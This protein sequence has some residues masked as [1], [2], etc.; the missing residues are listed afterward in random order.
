[1]YLYCRGRIDL[2]III[3]LHTIKLNTS[4][5]KHT[6][7]PLCSVNNLIIF[8]TPFSFFPFTCIYQQVQLLIFIIS[9]IY[10]LTYQKFVLW[11]Y[12]KTKIFVL[13]CLVQSKMSKIVDSRKTFYFTYKT[14]KNC[15]QKTFYKKHYILL[16]SILQLSKQDNYQSVH[17]H[18]TILYYI[19]LLYGV[20][21]IKYIQVFIIFITQYSDQEQEPGRFYLLQ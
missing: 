18:I 5:V 14:N 11:L 20:G 3:Y 6:Y 19:I 9:T 1:M 13:C 10:F 4:I 16:T 21:N 17:F 2:S 7:V 8:S 15:P 12:I